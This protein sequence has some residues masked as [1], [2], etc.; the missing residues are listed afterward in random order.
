MSSVGKYFVFF[1]ET[2]AVNKNLKKSFFVWKIFFVIAK[3]K[4]V[5]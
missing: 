2:I 4:N 3:C 5:V 1:K